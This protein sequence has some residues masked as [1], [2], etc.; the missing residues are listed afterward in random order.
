MN[1]K[2]AMAPSGD[3]LVCCNH[4]PGVAVQAVSRESASVDSPHPFKSVHGRKRTSVSK[5][6][7]GRVQK[8]RGTIIPKLEHDKALNRVVLALISDHTELFKQFSDNPSFK[9]WLTD[10]VFDSTY[11]PPAPPLKA[12]ELVTRRG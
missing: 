12:A 10:M 4:S 5:R 1:P 8:R 11:E 3:V 2:I 9:G 7:K 6:N